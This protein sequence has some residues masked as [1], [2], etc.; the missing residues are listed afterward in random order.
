MEEIF[1]NIYESKLW[2]NNENEKYSGSS[3]GGSTVSYNQ[4]YVIFLKKLILENNISSVID[5]GCGDF[6]CGKLIYDD[7]NI[8][9]KGYDTYKKVIDYNST[10]YSL[11]KYSFTHLDIYN[12]RDLI[13]NGDLCILKDILQHWKLENIY[14]FL[15]YLI[16]NKKFKYILICNCGFQ[17]ED[18]TD[19]NNGDWRPLSCHYLPLKKYN[20][21][22]LYKYKTKEVSIITVN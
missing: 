15:D 14:I 9:Y 16:Q 7:L 2:G 17:T 10:Q 8:A 21:I 1:T 4:E 22:K 20:P 19:I 5:L 3:G 11:P 18:N 6:I 13:I 12:N